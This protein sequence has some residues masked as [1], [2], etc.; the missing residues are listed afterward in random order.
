MRLPQPR[1]RFLV[2]LVA[3]LITIVVLAVLSDVAAS[4]NG[5]YPD[6]WLV[7][8]Y[9]MV[10]VILGT[11]FLHVSIQGV[12]SLHAS[13]R[14]WK[15]RRFL[16]RKAYR[17]LMRRSLYESMSHYTP[18]IRHRRDREVERQSGDHGSA[19]READPATLSLPAPESD[20]RRGDDRGIL[21]RGIEVVRL[22]ER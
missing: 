7:L 4:R 8:R 9:L 11:I 3:Q 13:Y 15:Q 5:D 10:A 21:R 2:L 16:R 20:D 17:V 6:W 22:R 1:D 14:H 19:H 18:P 12:I